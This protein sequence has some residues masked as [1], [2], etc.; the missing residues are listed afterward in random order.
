FLATRVSCACEW[1]TTR[2]GGLAIASSMKTFR[3]AAHSCTPTNGRATGAVIQPMPQSAMVYTNG[4]AMMTM[5]AN[6]KSIVTPEKGLVRRSVRPCLPGRP[7]ALPTSICG[8]VSFMVRLFLERFVRM[9]TEPR[10]DVHREV[11]PHEHVPLHTGKGCHMISL[12]AN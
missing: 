5:M 2:T 10:I 1:A 12:A 6:A 9:E 7:Q 11:L 3:L 4:R 8:N